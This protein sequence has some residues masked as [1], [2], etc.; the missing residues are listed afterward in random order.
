MVQTILRCVHYLQVV[1][2]HRLLERV[3]AAVLQ[4]LSRHL[5]LAAHQQQGLLLGEFAKQRR[6]LEQQLARHKTSLHPS[7]LHPSR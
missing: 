3:P 4:L 5:L 1:Q 7:M 6:L 2:A